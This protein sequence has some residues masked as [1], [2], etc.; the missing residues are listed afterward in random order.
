[1]R[2]LITAVLLG[3]ALTLA[4]C[5]GDATDEDADAM[6]EDTA[7]TDTTVPPPAD[8]TEPVPADTAATEPADTATAEPAEEGSDDAY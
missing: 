6:A 7:A 4:A 1:M 8:T 5:G 3:S 2:K